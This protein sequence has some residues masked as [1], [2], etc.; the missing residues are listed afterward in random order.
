MRHDLGDDA[1]RERRLSMPQRSPNSR[2]REERRSP[3]P[4]GSNHTRRKPVAPIWS[5]EPLNRRETYESPRTLVRDIAILG[6]MNLQRAVPG[7]LGADHHPEEY[8]LHILR[9]GRMNLWIDSPEQ[10]YL[11]QGGMASLTKPGQLH[12]GAADGLILPGRYT[13]VQFRLPSGPRATSS[14][15][16][17]RQM[18]DLRKALNAVNPPVFHYSPALEH[19]MERLLTEHRRPSDE[20]PIVARAILIELMVWITRDYRDDMLRKDH[21]PRGYSPVISKVLEWL[22]KNLD[23]NASVGDLAAIAGLSESYFRTWFHRELGSSPS[24]YVTQLRIERAKKLLSGPKRSV[25]DIA[26]DLG[27][28]TSAYFTAVFHRETGMTPSAFR[29]QVERE[30]GTT[31]GRT[32]Q[33]GPSGEAGSRG[34]TNADQSRKGNW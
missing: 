17:P 16:T 33:P 32:D 2:R 7:A 10:Q 28:N 20:S 3:R 34:K 12:G 30:R 13:W 8:E 22:E 19:C 31:D 21:E 6:Q 25:T 14:G 1:E 15:L 23:Q 24:D 18:S 9:D 5:Q 27:Y 4:G 29:E 11:L 26:M